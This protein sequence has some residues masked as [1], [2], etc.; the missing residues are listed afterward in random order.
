MLHRRRDPTA[1]KR[2]ACAVS[3]QDFSL[4]SRG[5]PPQVDARAELQDPL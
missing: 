1:M 5:W 3:H 4:V 2:A